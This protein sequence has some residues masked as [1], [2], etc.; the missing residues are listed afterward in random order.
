MRK[1]SYKCPL[2]GRALKIE[3][4]GEIWCWPCSK[5]WEISVTTKA[6][7]DVDYDSGKRPKPFV[8]HPK[9][10]VTYEEV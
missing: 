7:V 4:A 5:K 3:S 6:R 10:T 8:G 1:L 9:L 2:C